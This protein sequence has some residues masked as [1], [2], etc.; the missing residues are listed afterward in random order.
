ML[1]SETD[2][3]F[4]SRYMEYRE[5]VRSIHIF[6]FFFKQRRIIAYINIYSD[7]GVQLKFSKNIQ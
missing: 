7:L 2:A 1:P 4:F 5:K 3:P 6:L